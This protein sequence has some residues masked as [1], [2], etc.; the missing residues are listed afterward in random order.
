MSDDLLNVHEEVKEIFRDRIEDNDDL[1]DSITKS[2]IELSDEEITIRRTVEDSD[3]LEYVSDHHELPPKLATQR[4][5]MRLSQNRLSRDEV[6]EFVMTSPGSRG[7]ALNETLRV[8]NTENKRKAFAK[9]VGDQEDKVESLREDLKK[10]RD[11]FYDALGNSAP[12][13]TDEHV[14][15]DA[16]SDALDAINT[17]RDEY[18]VDQLSELDE[19]EFT[20]DIT[21][22][23]TYAR[24]HPLDRPDLR[25][26]FES[27]EEW[28]AWEG[29]KALESH[30]KLRDRIRE[31]Q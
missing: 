27:I 15:V 1:S 16:D 31:F 19:K 24:Y 23:A 12:K 9:A 7:K 20:A 17:L 22:P 29:E 5:A 21:E 10:Q 13:V 25:Q 11:D 26:E 6:L 8:Q 30:R 18:G 2:I 3:Q 14:T 28:F 4:T